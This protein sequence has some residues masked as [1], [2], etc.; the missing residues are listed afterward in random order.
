MNDR[1][2][3]EEKKTVFFSLKLEIDAVNASR[4]IFIVL[5]GRANEKNA[6]IEAIKENGAKSEETT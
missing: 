5:F 1:V 4:I 2:K 3:A 6:I